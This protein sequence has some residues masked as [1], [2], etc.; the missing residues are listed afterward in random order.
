MCQ[1]TTG[2]VRKIT[3]KIQFTMFDY[4]LRLGYQVID[5]RQQNLNELF[6]YSLLILY[7]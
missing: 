5:G 7:T 3:A 6:P 4:V 2:V 1:K